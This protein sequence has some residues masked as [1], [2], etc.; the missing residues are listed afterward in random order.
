MYDAEQRR[1]C[2]HGTKLNSQNLYGMNGYRIRWILLLAT[3]S[4][5][6]T[7]TVTNA[8]LLEDR[9][10]ITQS[11]NTRATENRRLHMS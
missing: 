4:M 8:P 5:P 6:V 7:V 1:Y 11:L 3:I 2:N 10:R 9:G